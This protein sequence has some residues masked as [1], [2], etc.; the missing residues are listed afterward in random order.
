MKYRTN[1]NKIEPETKRK[2][3]RMHWYNRKIGK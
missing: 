1:E 2:E 3:R